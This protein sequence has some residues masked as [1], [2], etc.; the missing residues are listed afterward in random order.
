MSAL[1][2]SQVVPRD[3]Q[4]AGYQSTDEF[5]SSDEPDMTSACIEFKKLDA[6]A[7]IPSYAHDGDAG[8]DVSIIGVH[9]QYSNNLTHYKTGLAVNPPPGYYF[10][11]FARSSLHKR[12]YNLGTGVSVF[13]PGYRGEIIVPLIKI[14]DD[15][16][17]LW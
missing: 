4:S 8:L 16:D 14:S 2:Q 17:P 3:D 1:S 6:N 15:A 9:Q 11:M 7:V 13:D 5:A 10:E 12:G